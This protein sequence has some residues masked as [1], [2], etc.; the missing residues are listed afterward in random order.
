MDRR[1]RRHP[2]PEALVASSEVPL[3]R[4]RPVIEP[5][6]V[7]LLATARSRVLDVHRHRL[8]IRRGRRD[9]SSNPAKPSARTGP[10]TCR[11]SDTHLD[12]NLTTFIPSPPRRH[13]RCHR[14]HRDH[15]PGHGHH[16]HRP[17]GVTDDPRHQLSAMSRDDTGRPSDQLPDQEE[18]RLLVGGGDPPVA[19]FGDDEVG[20]AVGGDDLEAG[21]ATVAGGVPP[22]LLERPRPAH[23]VTGCG[24]PPPMANVA[25]AA[26][27]S[28][29]PVDA[30]RLAPPSTSAARCT[31]AGTTAGDGAG[32]APGHGPAGRNRSAV[33]SA[34]VR[35][36]VDAG[37]H[38]YRSAGNR[39]P[40]HAGTS[41]PASPT[42]P[43][44]R[45]DGAG[46][47]LVRLRRTTPQPQ[48]VPVVAAHLVG[49]SRSST[50]PA[51]ARPTPSTRRAASAPARPSPLPTAR[52]PGTTPVRC[53]RRARSRPSP[54]AGCTPGPRRP[55]RR[56][57]AR[58]AACRRT[59]AADWCSTGSSNVC[60]TR[61]SG[62]GSLAPAPV[63]RRRR[64]PAGGRTDR[65]AE[66]RQH[67]ARRHRRQLAEPGQAEPGEQPDQLGVGLADVPQPGHRQRR[68]ER[69][70]RPG[71]T[72]TTPVP[73]RRA[74][75]AAAK[76]PSAMPTP[77]PVA[78]TSADSPRTVA[79][80][81]SANR[82]SPPK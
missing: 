11:T 51:V 24:G 66:P 27:S 6:I 30:H 49:L 34:S 72:T 7:E 4:R 63:G 75:T 71:S 9:R 70:E 42:N 32:S 81:R 61:R 35:S 82:W 44:S 54:P 68:E 20:G 21:Q 31:S 77:T 60:S 45:A 80:I 41:T 64:R 57:A 39:P 62:G 78:S 36:V 22:P 37:T 13:H 15:L 16:R 14:L 47:P 1:H 67:V 18:G 74:A 2:R 8:R 12:A 10:P 56:R 52:P 5:G 79:T 29:R 55:A 28:P 19:V 76:R 33:S 38:P 53:A 43:V 23:P 50:T 46:R 73:A 58:R 3:D 25:G 17:S 69:P 40:R 59:P 48:L 26:L 65:S